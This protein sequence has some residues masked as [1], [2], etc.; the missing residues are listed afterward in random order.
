MRGSVRSVH[1]KQEH[2]SF[3]V[4]P[5]TEPDPPGR[6]PDLAHGS[7]GGGGSSGSQSDSRSGPG[8]WRMLVKKPYDEKEFFFCKKCGRKGRC[9]SFKGRHRGCSGKVRWHC[10]VCG[11]EIYDSS[12]AKH[13]RLK[14]PEIIIRELP[15]AAESVSK[16]ASSHEADASDSVSGTEPVAGVPDHASDDAPKHVESPAPSHQIPK[17]IFLKSPYDKDDYYFC[18]RCGGKKHLNS[19]HRHSLIYPGVICWHCPVCKK[20]IVFHHRG[21]HLK[22]LHPDLIVPQQQ[23]CTSTT[24]PVPPADRQQ[25]VDVSVSEPGPSVDV[26]V[27]SCENPVVPLNSDSL[28]EL[29]GSTFAECALVPSESFLYFC[30]VPG[31]MLPSA[32]FQRPSSA[33]VVPE[34]CSRVE[35]SS[36]DVQIA[37]TSLTFGLKNDVAP[38]DIWMRQKLVVKNTQNHDVHV[39]VGQAT[40]SEA[41]HKYRVKAVPS[42]PFVLNPGKEETVTI[43]MKILCAADN[44]RMELSIKTWDDETQCKEVVLPFVTRS[45]VSKR[46]DPEK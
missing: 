41:L 26:D 35:Q 1:V 36:V 6:S 46:L 32:L 37:P 11:I 18:D 15:Q 29:N 14:R 21:S 16:N 12:R 34:R 43:L 20:N 2:P 25:P 24:D 13:L 22:R 31:V 19:W 38:V 39:I 5:Q 45:R 27:P 42:K 4:S 9:D 40:D 23:P 3:V 33:A 17:S 44:V 30:P 8:M 10:P 7:G 28:P